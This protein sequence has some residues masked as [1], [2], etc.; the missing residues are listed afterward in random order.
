MA[1]GGAAA[2]GGAAALGGAAAQ[3][4]VA[5]SGP[6]A[7]G[8]CRIELTCAA[9]IED[10]P[11]TD[12]AFSIRDSA[13]TVFYSARAGVELRG[14]SSLNYLKQN[15]A[16]ELRDAAGM[17]NPVPMF[18][19]GK[20]SDWVLDG[21]WV[22]RSF[23]RNDLV[24]SLFRDAGHYAAESK[25]CTLTLNGEN[26][27]IYRFGEK[28]KR[29][30][31]RVALVEDDGTG[32]SFLINQDQE[33]TLRFPVASGQSM[34]NWKFVYPKDDVAT[35]AQRSAV[36]AWLN[37][38]QAALSGADPANATTGVFSYLDFEQTVD[39]VLLEEFSK[40]IDA[41]NLSLHLYRDAGGKAGFVPWDFDLAF[42]QPTLRTGTNELPERWVNN[43]TPFITSLSRVPALLQRL[44]PRWRELR[45][46]P[47]ATAQVLA[48]LDQLGSQLLPADLS[49]NFAR[50]PLSEVDFTDIYRPYSLYPVASYDEERTRL[51]AWVEARLT[52]ID[53]HIDTYPN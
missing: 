23:M 47:F 1:A 13:G 45:A 18:G 8:P 29:D 17:E 4:G 10:D 44:G 42:G 21:S 48:R 6:P 2:G 36:Q 20:E 7:P 40:N 19:M 49:A 34:T 16:V 3:G 37:G 15:Y 51:R 41:Y 9:E 32:K 22:D 28:I 5:G 52:W 35:A 11:K 30:D 14:R 43:R 50:W 39:F 12:C 31:D 25:I 26:Q 24:F 33:G 27:G 46:G 53:A 38:L